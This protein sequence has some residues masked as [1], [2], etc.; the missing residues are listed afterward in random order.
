MNKSFIQAYRLIL[1]CFQVVF[2]RSFLFGRL[3]SALIVTVTASIIA[4]SINIKVKK[5]Q[6]MAQ[7][8]G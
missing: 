7:L 1:C 5:G 4:N 8:S 6:H 2:H 3:F